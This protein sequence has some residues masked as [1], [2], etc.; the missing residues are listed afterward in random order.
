MGA[1]LNEC[2]WRKLYVNKYM[3]IVTVKRENALT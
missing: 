2:L 1:L 3:N